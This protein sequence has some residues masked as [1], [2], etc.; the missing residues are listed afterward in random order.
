MTEEKTW[1]FTIRDESFE[2]PIE[3]PLA[4]T[5]AF[6]RFGRALGGDETS[7][8]SGLA[9]LEDA[10]R[11]LF[12]DDF[13]RFM[14]TEPTQRELIDLFGEAAQRG[15]VTLGESSEPS[16]SSSGGADH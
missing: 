9:D 6:G 11:G 5:F 14:S 4:V 13:V 10:T 12:G 1:T 15:A 8:M 3:I 2:L 7:Q 16:T